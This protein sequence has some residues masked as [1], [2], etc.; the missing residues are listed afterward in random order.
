MS[1][2]RLK[3][4][5]LAIV[6]A[7]VPAQ[8]GIMVVV[9]HPDDDVIIAAG[10]VHAARLRGEQVNVVYTTNGEL[11]GGLVT[12]IER[13]G[14]A[15]NAQSF[16]GVGENELIFLGY[17]DNRLS[18]LFTNPS[19]AEPG[20]V[21]TSVH[22][23]SVT[24]GNRGLGHADYHQHRFGMHASFNKKNLLAD[25]ADVIDTYRPTH[26]LTHA[27]FDVHPDHRQVSMA[28][29]DAMRVVAA[30]DAKYVATLFHGL[31]WSIDSRAWPLAANPA[32]YLTEPPG[33]APTGLRWVDRHSIDVP[34]TMMN[35]TPELNPKYLAIDAHVSQGGSGAFI[36][37]S[38]HRDEVFW[39]ENPTG[40]DRPP[41]VDAGK[42]LSVAPGAKVTLDGSQSADLDG[43]LTYKW[44]QR[45]GP[46][47]TLAGADTARP[48][49]TLPADLPNN[50]MVTFALVV[51]QGGVT[52]LEDRV[53]VQASTRAAA[54]ASTNIAPRA[55]VTASS[56]KAGSEPAKAVD[57]MVGAAK[58]TG[59]EWA[60]N[61]ERAGAW[62]QLEW[63]TPYTIDRVV[64]H[65]RPSPMDNTASVT[66]MFDGGVTHTAGP[67][68]PTGAGFPVTFPPVTTK[69]LRVKLDAVAPTTADAGLAELV[70]YGVMA[71][72]DAAQGTA[73]G[74]IAQLATVSASSPPGG[75]VQDAS[76]A[77]DGVV[78]GWP[79]DFS[80][81]WV[82]SGERVGAW[83][84]LEWSEPHVIDRVVLHD[85][86][87]PSD[88]I[89]NATL[90]IDDGA[91][92][93]SGPLPTDGAP[94]E[95]KFAPTV[96]RK[97]RIAISATTGG[98]QNAGLAEVKVYES[99][100]PAAAPVSAIK[101]NKPVNIAG[102][103]RVTASSEN[104]QSQQTAKKAVD[105]EVGGF[106]KAPGKEWV[107]SGEGAGAWIQLDWTNPHTVSRVVLFDRPNPADQIT[108]ATLTFSDGTT[109]T[110]PTLPNGGAKHVVNIP[111]RATT[112][113][114]V[115][116][117]A[118]KPGTS[119]AGLAE[120]EVYGTP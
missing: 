112:S 17:P 76:K 39:A 22:G 3:L 31:V 60:S 93:Q 61:G 58:D 19:Y 120:L 81:E 102:R 45:D 105:G 34:R 110:V 107:A 101:D 6:F 103:A 55:K 113:L 44:V 36:G 85:R 59:Y 47:V 83:L 46:Q 65:D 117:T 90:T 97:L 91:P 43:P 64:V 28:V 41:R 49:F 15:V 80:K 75:N 54:A 86:M 11:V 12:G 68:E 18:D 9:A 37:K 67:L 99:N 14:E 53:T 77:V 88:N 116:V 106:P 115:T 95:V 92:I 79:N 42:P 63:P 94:R 73:D 108:G 66:L 27:D 52:S 71:A 10:V 25:L 35:A 70:V 109:V 7:P 26:I 111:P 16:L 2:L 38:I 96:A 23:Q 40:T 13:Q 5:T 21:L 57:E 4:F 72:S 29:R 69:T 87:N 30:K 56:A 84:L 32:T 50:G 62:L 20:A 114:R 33:L 119:N 82:T 89:T 78:D 48:T 100:L 24:F 74:D 8:A 104:T 118:V 98:T 51:S 1:N